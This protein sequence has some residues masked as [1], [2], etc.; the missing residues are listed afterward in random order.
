MKATVIAT[1][2]QLH[3][4]G[5]IQ[6]GIGTNDLTTGSEVKVLAILENIHPNYGEMSEVEY[7]YEEL[8]FHLPTNWLKFD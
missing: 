1:K 4:I 8:N 2:E 5:I 7:L 6:D 3:S